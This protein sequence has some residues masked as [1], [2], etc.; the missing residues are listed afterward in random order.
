MVARGAG[1]V[2]EDLSLTCISSPIDPP[3]FTLLNPFHYTA[4]ESPFTSLEITIG[5]DKYAAGP[6][7]PPL[8]HFDVHGMIHA[9][10]CCIRIPVF[11]HNHF[12]RVGGGG[13]GEIN[14]MCES[15]HTMPSEMRGRGGGRGGGPKGGHCFSKKISNPIRPK[16]ERKTFARHFANFCPTLQTEGFL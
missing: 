4:T 6:H 9:H 16:F 15:K 12:A 14:E 13:G 8:A 7:T 2:G 11:P 5:Q 10:L 1:G 3:K